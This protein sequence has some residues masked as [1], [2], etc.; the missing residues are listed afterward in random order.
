MATLKKVSTTRWYIADPGHPKGR[1]EVKPQT[2]GAVKVREQGDTYYV[3]HRVAGKKRFVSTGLTDKRAA[4]KFM[5]DWLVA[6]ERGQ[7]G[8]TDPYKEHLDRPVLD[9]LAEY[10]ATLSDRS[11]THVREVERVLSVV[12]QST[13]MTTLKDL[14]AA[15]IAAYLTSHPASAA[16]RAKHRVY[17]SGFT[18][19]LHRVKQYLPDNPIDRV[20]VPRAG[21]KEPT[22]RTRRPYS[23]DEFRRLLQAARTYPVAARSTHKG[24]RPRKDGTPAQ[25]RKAVVLSPEFRATLEQQGRERELVYRL[26]LATGLRRGELSRVTVAMFDGRKITS[27]KRILKH[28][29][30]AITHVV[31]HVVPTLAAALSAW[32]AATKRTQADPLVG[33]P[34]P[35]NFVREHQARLKLAGIPYQTPDGFADIHAARMTANMILKAAGVPVGSRKRFLRHAARDITGKHYDADN[36]R[37]A[38]MTRRTFRTLSDLDRRLTATV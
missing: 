37:P 12:V 20:P 2:P 9:C 19:F 24:G 26:L 21:H 35:S 25:P 5:A 14:T 13:G 32:I 23:E 17:L 18:T 3:V 33:V 38:T 15:R 30:K 11:D 16:T 8:L 27:P 7:H 31:I 10:M 29:P 36:K 34:C 4:Q 22:P 6:R 1:R 28:K